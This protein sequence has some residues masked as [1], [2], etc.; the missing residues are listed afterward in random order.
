MLTEM[1]IFGVCG[2][3]GR[4]RTGRVWVM[5]GSSCAR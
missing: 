5:E 3:K 4:G 1:S 2:D